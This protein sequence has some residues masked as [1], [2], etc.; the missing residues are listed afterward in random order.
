MGG[1]SAPSSLLIAILSNKAVGTDAIISVMEC[2]KF[3]PSI[4]F[5]DVVK[6]HFTVHYGRC[7]DSGLWCDPDWLGVAVAAAAVTGIIMIAN[8]GKESGNGGGGRRSPEPPARRD[9]S[10][11]R[12]E[13]FEKAKRAGHG[14]P[15]RGPE[16]HGFGPHFHPKPKDPRKRHDHYH[17]PKRFI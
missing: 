3:Y 17:F 12:K 14:L 6:S 2:F 13:A 11:T 10:N 1:R 4:E 8:A 5:S 15:P 7:S 16:D 9:H